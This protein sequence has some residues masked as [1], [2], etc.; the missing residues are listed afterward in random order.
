MHAPYTPTK[1]LQ[2]REGLLKGYR[3]NMGYADL[4]SGSSCFYFPS[5]VI[6]DMVLI[7]SLLKCIVKYLVL[8]E[9]H[10]GCLFR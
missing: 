3:V 9:F 7:V 4:Q 5:V 8:K 2:V 10:N 1:T 6:V